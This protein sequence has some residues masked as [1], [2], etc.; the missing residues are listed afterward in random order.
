[1][2]P[3]T[4]APRKLGDFR[5]VAQLSEDALG[6]VY[7]A[8]DETNDGRFL[9]L[10]ILQ[11]PDLSPDE[12]AAAI[13]A[14]AAGVAEL[15]HKSIAQRGRLGFAGSVPYLAW[16]EASGWT[17]DAVFS[18]LRAAKTRIPLP[19]AVLVAQRIAAALEHAWFTVI[20]GEPTRHG[21]LW[22]GFVAISPDAEVRV[23]G[24]GLRDAVLPSLHK[25]RL[26]REIAPYVPPE[27][28]STGISG[29]NADVYSIGVLLAEIAT[30]RRAGAAPDPAGLPPEELLSDSVQPVLQRAFAPP[31]ERFASAAELNRALQEVLAR[32]PTSIASGELALFLY[33]LLNPESRSV[34]QPVDGD[35]TNPVRAGK[36]EEQGMPAVTASEAASARPPKPVRSGAASPDGWRRWIAPAAAAI[37]VAAVWM[38]FLLV[39]RWRTPQIAAIPSP[40]P[41][42]TAIAALPPPPPALESRAPV[43]R[44]G[45]V[46]RRSGGKARPA[47]L[48]QRTPASMPLLP[49]RRSVAEA[50]R[51][52][53]GLA[54]VAAERLEAPELANGAFSAALER[55]QAGEARLRGGDTTAAK[56]EFGRATGLFREAEELARQERV[57]RVK[58]GGDTE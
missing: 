15:S 40:A 20:E 25:P 11:A 6:T 41:A 2:T 32:N 58:V 36:A 44:P 21:L 8:L 48:Q 47:S 13:R 30:G 10:R 53:A 38:A 29:E 37:G 54:R 22:P 24:F 26:A 9:R 17:L 43:E 52:E 4:F 16:Q 27:A 49:E 5:L 7:R 56:S 1:M 23:G 42:A 18:K 14:H 28:R 33:D 19:Y 57:R 46:A 3:A 12:V 39:L 35:S 51:L 31:S 55:E 50:A 34:A 45:A